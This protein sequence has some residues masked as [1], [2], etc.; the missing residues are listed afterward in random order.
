MGSNPTGHDLLKFLERERAVGRLDSM[1][2]STYRTACRSVLAALPQGLDTLVD[3]LDLEVARGAFEESAAATRLATA[4]RSTYVSSFKAAVR[5]FRASVTTLSADAD[6][7]ERQE[8]FVL[9]TFP[10]RREREAQLEVPRNLTA[11]EADRLCAFVHSLVI[12]DD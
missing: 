11:P 5:A 7:G 10:L 12:S 9:Y 2:V 3:R 1:T 4:T 6:Y 8:P